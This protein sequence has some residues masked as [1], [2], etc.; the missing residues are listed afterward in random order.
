[1]I[2]LRST[3][4]DYLTQDL[5]SAVAFHAKTVPNKPFHVFLRDGQRKPMSFGELWDRSG[6]FAAALELRSDV[7]GRV[8][9]V[10]MPMGPDLLATF[11]GAMRIGAIPSIM[12]YPNPK[13]KSDLF[14]S[15]HATL[16]ERIDPVCFVL[17]PAIAEQYDDNLPSFKDRILRT[18]TVHSGRPGPFAID[19]DA[20]AFL[21]HS[22]GT[23]SLKKG[24]KLTHRC[25]VDHVRSYAARCGIDSNSRLFSWLPLY[26]DMGLIACFV[27]PMVMGATVVAMDNFEWVARPMAMLD[28]IQKDRLEFAWMPNFGFAHLTRT[29]SNPG[30]FDLSS[31]KALINCSEPCRPETHDAFIAHFEPAGLDSATVQVCYAMAE[32]VFAVS[33]TPFGAPAPALAVC[34]N[35][36]DQGLIKAADPRQPPLLIA[37]CGTVL[38]DTTIGIVDDSRRPVPERQIGEVTIRSPHLF[39]G[40]NQ[41]DDL[42]KKALVDG[43]YYTG[44]LGFISEG[45]LYLTGR[46]DDLILAY[47]R[48]L[49]AHE[50]EAIIN[51]V[52][53]VKPGR[54]TVFGVYV[55]QIGSNV[56]VVMAETLRGAGEADLKRAIRTSLEAGA[57]VA[58]H[59]IVLLKDGDLRKTTSGKISRNG[60][61]T[62]YLQT[63]TGA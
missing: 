17:S 23:T 12:P 3:D 27:M 21:Q 35:A 60:N 15:S 4:L 37:S 16:F 30:E 14:W 38:P 7:R 33:Q 11:L 59:D 9:I 56:L 63:Q 18:D 55:E 45:Q 6:D 22:S 32:N 39:A 47:G 49:L 29:C 52:P 13:Q 42:T 43:I 51:S 34:Q 36:F 57:G 44:D 25:V 62:V 50:L 24:V 26:H 19:P 31:L 46:K 28:A 1:M 53:G 54:V 2:S 40:Y 5:C 58:P 10:S 8:V 20:V 48:N 61:R 41:R